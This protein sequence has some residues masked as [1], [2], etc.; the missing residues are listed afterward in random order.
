MGLIITTSILQSELIKLLKR[1]YFKSVIIYADD[2]LIYSKGMSKDEH[3]RLV[4]EILKI[5]S[6]VGMKVSPKKVQLAKREVSFLGMLLSVKGWKVK[7]DF[8]SA[9]K[10][11]KS[12]FLEIVNWQ[13]DFIQDSRI[14]SNHYSTN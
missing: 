3:I 11:A 12:S 2:I 5:L 13:R 6:D 8:I 4:E 14:W 10:Q 7:Q 1:Y 9:L